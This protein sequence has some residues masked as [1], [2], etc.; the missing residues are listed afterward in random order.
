M[1]AP[2]GIDY[3]GV[4]W[5]LNNHEIGRI[6]GVDHSSVGAKRRRLGKMPVEKRGGGNHQ[7]PHPKR[8]GIDDLDYEFSCKSGK[9]QD[10]RGG[11]S[12]WRKAVIRRYGPACTNCN[13]LKPGISNH[14][15]HIIPRSQGGKNTIRNGIVL[16]SRCHDE[17]HAGI[18]I[19]KGRDNGN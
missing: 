5:S 7:V 8:H 3:S 9:G 19:L 13:Y 18:L 2:K 4:D 16:C 17:V 6:L 1:A 12:S 10:G 14:C 11:G 15:H